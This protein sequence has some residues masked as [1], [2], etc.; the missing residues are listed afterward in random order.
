[1]P[2]L[3]YPTSTK[4][5]LPVLLSA[6]ALREL[7]DLLAK[8]LQPLLKQ[9]EE[10]IPDKVEERLRRFADPR[11]SEEELEK[12]RPRYTE[13]VR[14][15]IVGRSSTR[16]RIHFSDGTRLAAQ[17]FEEAASHPQVLNSTAG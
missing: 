8:Q 2:E 12:R 15:E 6:S 5:R 1:M 10:L 17:S 13:E 4:I 16:L 3:T 14:R 11:D 7:D 9:Q